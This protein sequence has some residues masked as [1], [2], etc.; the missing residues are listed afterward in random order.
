MAYPDK[1]DILRTLSKCITSL[2]CSM[3]N[4]V[5]TRKVL[6]ISACVISTAISAYILW[7]KYKSY[8]KSQSEPKNVT[9]LVLDDGIYTGT[10]L[11]R[12]VYYFFKTIF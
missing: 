4:R 7:Q 8:R 1:N 10:T 9:G 12:F 2:F 6:A 11:V 5:S 3:T